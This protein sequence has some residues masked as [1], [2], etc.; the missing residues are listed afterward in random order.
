[1]QGQGTSSSTN[2][3]VNAVIC[4]ATTP[5][6]YLPTPRMACSILG[7][8][9]TFSMPAVI[10]CWLLCVLGVLQCPAIGAAGHAC[11]GG[12]SF[13]IEAICWLRRRCHVGLGVASL[14][15]SLLSHSRSPDHSRQFGFN[16]KPTAMLIVFHADW[17]QQIVDPMGRT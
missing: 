6:Y 5:Q 10:T 14:L 4:V 15:G 7:S 3:V 13:R 1:M 11:L 17:S 2:S 8:A 9:Q 16:D 12:C